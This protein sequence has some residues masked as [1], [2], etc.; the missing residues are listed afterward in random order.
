MPT[1]RGFSLSIGLNAVSPDHYGGWD[2]KLN[3]C[4]NDAY[5]FDELLCTSGFN[6]LRLT[7]TPI[8]IYKPQRLPVQATMSLLLTLCTGGK[9]SG[10]HH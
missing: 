4:E 5:Y 3:A 9:I 7:H 1:N 10:R 2:G 8:G 6:K